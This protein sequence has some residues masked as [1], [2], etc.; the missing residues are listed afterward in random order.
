MA[1]ERDG[2]L[3]ANRTPVVGL[4]ASAGGLHALQEFFGALPADIGAA[5]VVIV[6]LGPGHSSELA[7]ILSTCTRL[8][9][10][11]V[12]GRMPLEANTVFVI[13]PNRRLLINGNDISTAEFNEPRGQRAPID[14]FFRSLAEEHG[15]GF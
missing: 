2:M 14:L 8:P 6:H 5:L 1:G 3:P 12:N 7:N 10:M 15:D 4:G 11:Q 9:V 13:P